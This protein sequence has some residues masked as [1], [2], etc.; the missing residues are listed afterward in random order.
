MTAPALAPDRNRELMAEF[1][2]RQAVMYAGGP[3]EPVAELLAPEVVW[4]V[5]GRSPIAGRHRGRQSV[6]D[7][8]ERRRAL[9]RGTLRIAVWQSVADEEG[10]VEL[11]DGSAQ[12]DGEPAAWRTAGVYRIEDG[13][14]A[15][16]WLVPFDL[17][18]FDRVWS[19]TRE[20]LYVH[21]HES[22][23]RA[24]DCDRRGVLSHPRLLE[25]LEGAFIEAW[26]AHARTPAANGAFAITALELDY[27]SPARC[28]DL[29]LIDVGFDREAERE[30]TVHHAVAVGRRQVADARAV[31]VAQS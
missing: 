28:D 13:K 19:R 27:L 26:R 15:E 12:L 3:V 16:A 18:D 11:A 2:R 31:Y 1:R 17:A 4:H 5:P 29:L 25:H 22:R 30:V 8:F 14:V 24:Q 6:I 21:A 23:V 20:R 10:V 9:A 7:Y